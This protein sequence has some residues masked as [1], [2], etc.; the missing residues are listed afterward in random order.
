MQTPHTNATPE[1]PDIAELAKLLAGLRD[2]MVTM[3]LSL[4]D[5]QFE[6]D[7]QARQ[8]AIQMTKTLLK[9]HQSGG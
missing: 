5:Y 2:A 8:A 4:R 3:A 9:Q 7:S 1:Q 6:R